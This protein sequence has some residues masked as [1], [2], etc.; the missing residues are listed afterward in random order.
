[1][2]TKYATALM[3]ITLVF[4]ISIASIVQKG[5]IQ[6]AQIDR[7]QNKDASIFNKYRTDSSKAFPKILMPFSNLFSHTFFWHKVTSENSVVR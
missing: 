4:S 5:Y 3:L 7:E 1:M 6:R 2:N